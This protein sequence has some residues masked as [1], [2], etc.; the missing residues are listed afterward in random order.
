MK[1][2]RIP[3]LAMAVFGLIAFCTF[4]NPAAAQGGRQGSFTLPNE[5][6]WQGVV[7]PAGEYTFSL[8]STGLSAKVVVRGKNIGAFVMAIEASSSRTDQP[9]ELI[10]ERRSGSCFVRELYLAELGLHLR[11]SVPKAPKE[12]LLAQGPTTTERVLISKVGK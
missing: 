2:H 12:Q 11:Y 1:S 3:I 6:R 9:S 5:V 7:L 10:I 8:E 4:A